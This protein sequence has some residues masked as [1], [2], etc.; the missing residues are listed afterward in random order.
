MREAL[1]KFVV[2]ANHLRHRDEEDKTSDSVCAHPA[3]VWMRIN[4]VT[5]RGALFRIACTY[6]RRKMLCHH[7]EDFF[8]PSPCITFAPNMKIYSTF[9]FRRG[10]RSKFRVLSSLLLSLHGGRVGG[11][12]SCVIFSTCFDFCK[13][14]ETIFEFLWRFLRCEFVSEISRSQNLLFACGV[15][16]FKFMFR[17]GVK[18][19]LLKMDGPWKWDEIMW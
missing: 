9:G 13:T 2:Y 14:L 19:V 16:N 18:K 8:F 10:S 4:K 12:A 15:C 7:L 17:V 1:K 11:N 6:R 3:R 5:E